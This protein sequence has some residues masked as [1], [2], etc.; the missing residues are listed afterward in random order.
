MDPDTQKGI[1]PARFSVS[2]GGYDRDQVDAYLAELT[3]WIEGMR[4]GLTPSSAV[5]VE[6]ARI[7]E[8]T[9]GLLATAGDAAASIVADAEA[10]A[11]KKRSQ[12]QTQAEQILAAGRERSGELERV[13]ADLDE[14]REAL[15]SE[16]DSLA[17]SLNEIT[18]RHREE[19]VAPPAEPDLVDPLEPI[20]DGGR[21]SSWLPPRSRRK[22]RPL[23]SRNSARAPTGSG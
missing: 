11:E 3:D 9:A 17:K 18:T 12:A 23:S 19:G 1:R 10:L 13:I 2:P 15:L 7:G 6:L 20:G 14:R 22:A 4:A 16:L 8:R 21:F 5:Q